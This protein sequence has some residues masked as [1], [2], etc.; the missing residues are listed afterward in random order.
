MPQIVNEALFK[1]RSI[2]IALS[3]NMELSDYSINNNYLKKTHGGT[4]PMVHALAM[5]EDTDRV[6]KM[7]E[8]LQRV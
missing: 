3:L 8:K 7:K 4:V 1:A 5:Q 6:T 2:E